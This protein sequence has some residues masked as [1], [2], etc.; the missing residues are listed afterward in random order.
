ME[1]DSLLQ[2]ELLLLPPYY[3]QSTEL[4]EHVHRIV[5]QLYLQHPCKGVIYIYFFKYKH[6]I[7]LNKID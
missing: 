3:G 2:N 5:C 4:G 1:Q 6:I 7:I